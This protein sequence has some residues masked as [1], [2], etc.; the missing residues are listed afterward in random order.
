MS[1]EIQSTDSGDGKPKKGKKKIDTQ[2]GM[3]SGIVNKEGKTVKAPSTDQSVSNMAEYMKKNSPES[4]V[5]RIPFSHIGITYDR[6][7]KQKDA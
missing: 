6:K 7:K 5:Y 4:N 3:Y 1:H 2:Y